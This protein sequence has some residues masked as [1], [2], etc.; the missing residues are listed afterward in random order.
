MI[1]YGASIGCNISNDLRKKSIGFGGRKQK[2]GM[3]REGDI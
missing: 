2:E 1:Q 3:N